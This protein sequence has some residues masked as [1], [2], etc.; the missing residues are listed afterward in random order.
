[1]SVAWSTMAMPYE[2]RDQPAPIED[3]ILHLA[4]E[5]RELRLAKFATQTRLS[6]ES[7]ISQGTSSNGMAPGWASQSPSYR[8][9]MTAPLWPPRPMLFDSA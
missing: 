6:A 7:G 1:M 2:L 9:K 4:V 5:L 3:V 8:L